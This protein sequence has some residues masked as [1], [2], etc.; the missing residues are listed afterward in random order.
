MIRER[1]QVQVRQLYTQVVKGRE[2][3]SL[4]ESVCTLLFIIIPSTCKNSLF[5]N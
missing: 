3:E 4:T 5:S 1:K 2:G